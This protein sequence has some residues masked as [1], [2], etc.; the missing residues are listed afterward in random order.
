MLLVGELGALP[1]V[2]ADLTQLV[3]VLTTSTA[4][5]GATT[6]GS[7]PSS[8]TKSIAEESLLPDDIFRKLNRGVYMD[9]KLEELPPVYWILASESD[10]ELI[11]Q[12]PITDQ[13]NVAPITKE[14]SKE[15]IN[16]AI[17]IPGGLRKLAVDHI[18]QYYRRGGSK[19][20]NM[21]LST[22]AKKELDSL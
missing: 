20:L 22:T 17:E 6:G 15:A 7:A 12:M 19:S 1:P 4:M 13:L 3:T 16:Q 9:G 18:V 2:V 10:E 8:P 21:M 14:V 5:K 11:R